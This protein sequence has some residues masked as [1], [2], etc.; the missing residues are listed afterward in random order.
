M[1][2]VAEKYGRGCKERRV[3]VALLSN[4]HPVAHYDEYL[5]GFED[6]LWTRESDIQERTG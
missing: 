2:K 1:L 5:K 6:A 4:M 3:R